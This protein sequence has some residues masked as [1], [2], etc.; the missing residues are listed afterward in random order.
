MAVVGIGERSRGAVDYAVKSRNNL[1]G[2]II[3]AAGNGRNGIRCLANAPPATA[4]YR[5][6]QRRM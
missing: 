4:A 1:E 2:T 3:V 5:A 6:P